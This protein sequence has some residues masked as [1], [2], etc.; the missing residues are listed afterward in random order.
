MRNRAKIK[1]LL[2]KPGLDGH[3]VGVKIIARALM[4]S[5]F[6]VLY[7]GLKKSPNEIVGR[8]KAE[9]INVLGLSILSGSHIPICSCMSELLRAEGL[10]EVLW[11][12][13]GN[14]PE[15]DFQALYDLGVAEVFSVGSSPEAVADFIRENAS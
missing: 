11:V 3:D 7:T 5:G 8:V 6:E 9:N 14:I 10:S 12:V 4:D 15:R 2:A 1:V 13:G